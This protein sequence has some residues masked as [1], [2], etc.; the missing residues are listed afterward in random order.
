MTLANHRNA[1]N[2]L[3]RARGF[4][5]VELMV[6]LAIGLVLI[7]ALV[8]LFIGTS[9]N[10]RE[11]AS[12][13][14]MIENGRFA[15]QLLEND[16]MHAGF[17]GTYVPFFDDVTA[18]TGVPTDT[19]G[20]ALPDPCLDYAAWTAPHV[21]DLLG[22][23]VQ[24]Y[25]ETQVTGTPVCA[26]VVSDM[27][28]DSD[29]LV[30]RHA[31][32]CVPGVAP[33][34]A[35]TNGRLYL[36]SSLC[37]TDVQRFVLGQTGVDAFPLRRIDCLTAADKREFV[38]SMYYVRDFAVTAG[39]GVPTLVRSSFAD[40]GGTLAH[41]PPVALVEGID[42]LRVEFGVDSL[43]GTGAAVDYTTQTAW[44]NNLNKVM[45]T[46][47]GDGIPDGVFVRCDSVTP[48]DGF[49]LADAAPDLANVTAVRIY[50][51]AR[52]R[53]ATPGYV[54]N[55]TYQLGSAPAL[56]PYNDGFKR[57]VY[58]TTVRLPNVSGRR[59]RP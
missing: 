47:R 55:K 12:A 52:S 38:S 18:D 28:P 49:N 36:Q 19:P 43:S 42:A 1:R 51:L 44:V 39:D 40:V 9:R 17:W 31:E 7:A 3:R 58:T 20:A 56:G 26:G 2:A 27:S 11:M 29:L 33:C 24:A 59:E 34:D 53:E 16:V 30:V 10:N 37:L 14:S 25:D 5:L 13:N 22:V 21:N 46:N 32:L 35:D 15:I 41:Q 48:C 23:P 50:V 57:H 54:D 45:A 8:A 6:S 4:G